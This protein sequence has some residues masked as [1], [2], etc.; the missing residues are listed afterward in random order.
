MFMKAKESLVLITWTVLFASQIF[1]Q[2]FERRGKDIF[3]NPSAL[4]NVRYETFGG[5]LVKRG[6]TIGIEYVVR[7]GFEN[8]DFVEAIGHLDENNRFQPMQTL[9]F[10]FE[11]TSTMTISE[12]SDVKPSLVD[13]L[14]K[15]TFT[16]GRTLTD[17]LQKNASRMDVATKLLTWRLLAQNNSQNLFDGAFRNPRAV[18]EL[19]DMWK[20]EGF[21]QSMTQTDRGI[22]RELFYDFMTA[23]GHKPGELNIDFYKP[24]AA[25]ERLVLFPSLK[26]TFGII[27]EQIMMDEPESTMELIKKAVDVA[28]KATS[29]SAYKLSK[30]PSSTFYVNGVINAIATE[31]SL[32]SCALSAG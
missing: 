27:I 14:V 17:F 4:P 32:R 19:F 29:A 21:R 23:E 9:N 3:F 13:G 11:R 31:S 30:T 10:D 7:S 8:L 15:S 24:D 26:N 12:R 22:L 2:G 16:G 5:S 25:F 18:A 6:S 28:K 20:D 1:G